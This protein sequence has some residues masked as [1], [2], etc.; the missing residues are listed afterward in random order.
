MGSFS[1]DY[2]VL[3]LLLE[4]FNEEIILQDDEHHVNIDLVK[5]IRQNDEKIYYFGS[6]IMYYH[7]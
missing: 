3:K 6:Y 7:Y 2:W 5:L 1:V 4:N